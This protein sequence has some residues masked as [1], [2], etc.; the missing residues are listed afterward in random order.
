MNVV[1]DL[2]PDFHPSIDLDVS[3]GAENIEAGIYLDAS[4]VC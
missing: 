1:P 2:L 4:L 3:F